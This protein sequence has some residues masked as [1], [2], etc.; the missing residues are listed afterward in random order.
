MLN[1]VSVV[2][3]SFGSLKLCD[4]GGLKAPIIFIGT[5]SM[6]STCIN[7]IPSRESAAL[8]EKHLGASLAKR[9]GLGIWGR[10]LSCFWGVCFVLSAVFLAE[11]MKAAPQ[12][13]E[14]KLGG[15]IEFAGLGFIS[16][17]LQKKVAKNRIGNELLAI[18]SGHECRMSIFDDK[19]HVDF[20]LGTFRF[21]ITDLVNK[22]IEN[23]HYCL[24]FSGG[25][26]VIPRS[27]VESSDM[28]EQ[29]EGFWKSLSENLKGA[30]K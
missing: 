8:V 13:V 24:I 10:A 1:L 6:Y 28:K 18:N 9:A 21:P 5:S 22:I 14:S 29:F 2:R 16:L 17:K 15:F 30:K 20:K 27:A 19:V 3:P 4:N 7:W 26:V 25:A 23:D 11:A 12:S